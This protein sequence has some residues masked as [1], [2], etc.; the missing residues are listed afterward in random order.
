MPPLVL[1]DIGV[2]GCVLGLIYF[3]Q[4]IALMLFNG[5]TAHKIIQN[6]R[7]SLFNQYI[8]DYI[9]I[10]YRNLV[11]V[12]SYKMDDD[13]KKYSFLTALF[14]ITCFTSEVIFSYY[15]VNEIYLIEE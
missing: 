8:S 3:L 7:I 14:F 6:I 13:F 10:T 5:S 11:H 4:I 9:G 12:S 1:Q 15:K 2:T